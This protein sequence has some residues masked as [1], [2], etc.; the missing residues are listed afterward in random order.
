LTL[1]LAPLRGVDRFGHRGI[2]RRVQH[3]AGRRARTLADNRVAVLLELGF[4]RILERQEQ[5]GVPAGGDHAAGQA[6]DPVGIAA[7]L[8][9][10]ANRKAGLHIGYGF[11]MA[12]DDPAPGNQVRRLARLSR[13]GNFGA[14]HHDPHVLPLDA[15]ICMVR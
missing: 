6:D 11:V 2:A 13:L 4:L 14:H 10:I 7:H 3:R 5:H 1:V 12:L 8:H 9:L 15:T